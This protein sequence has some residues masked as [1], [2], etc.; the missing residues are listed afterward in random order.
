MRKR[1]AILIVLILSVFTLGTAGYRIIEGWNILDSLYMT[2]ITLT[3][4]GFQEVHKLSYAGRIFTIIFVL[5][6]IGVLAYAINTGVRIIFEGEIKKALGRVKLEKK[7]KLLKKHYIVCGYGRIGRIICKELKAEKVPFV[8][9][10]HDV[11]ELDADDD[12]LFVIGD[13]TRDDILKASG[14][15]RAKGLVSVLSTDAQNLYVVLSARGLNPDLRIIARAGEEGSER[16]LVRAG[17]DRVVSP[18]HIGGLRIAHTILKPAVVDFLE[19]ATKTGNIEMQMEEIRVSDASELT[20]SSLYEKGIG[21]QLGVIIVSIK[22][23]DGSMTFNPTSRTVI[24]SGDV[25]IALGES[26]KL[27]EL[28]R[29]AGRNEV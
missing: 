11:N 6:G 2:I 15:E 25:L 17:A 8:V 21:R 27:N 14:I 28:E 20:G 29:L 7:I 18:Y 12:T 16:K 10:E 4:I 22:R 26:Q 19:F 13:A 1:L 9:I 24:H 3:T 5:F 23:A